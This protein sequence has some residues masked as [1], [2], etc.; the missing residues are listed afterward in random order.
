MADFSRRQILSVGSCGFGALAFSGLSTSLMVAKA[1]SA[2]L[3]A[4]AKRIIFLCMPGGPA[5]LDTF[6]YKPQT[7]KTEHLGSAFKFSQHGKSGLWI[8]ELFPELAKHAD[9]LCVLNGM[10]ADT[11]N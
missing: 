11:G 6:D 10:Y 7:T 5:H 1:N 2:N 9:K 8:S 3:K 4:R